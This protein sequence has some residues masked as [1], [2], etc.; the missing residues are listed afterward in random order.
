[1][2][3]IELPTYEFVGSLNDVLPFVSTEKDDPGYTVVRMD[4]TGE[5]LFFMASN[6]HQHVQY[7]TDN[8]CWHNEPDD[9]PYSVRIAH[10]DAKM[11][12]SAFK[13]PTKHSHVT[14]GISV[15]SFSVADNLY[16]VT[17]SREG[18]E[19][20]SRLALNVFG[21]GRPRGADD[22]PEADIPQEIENWRGGVAS[23]EVTGWYAKSLA[24]FGKVER[25]GAIVLEFLTGKNGGPVRV[26]S[27]PR[28]QGIAFQAKLDD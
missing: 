17:F 28:F 7:E 22:T 11:L 10:S 8:R 14:V 12:A 9:E 1:M 5:G 16:R 21:R 4:W 25:H 15:S 6:R 19:D 26:S 13:L 20:Y 3:M 24:N 18:S 27:G 23:Q 2:A